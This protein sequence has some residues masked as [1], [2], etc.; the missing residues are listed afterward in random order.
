MRAEAAVA[1][2]DEAAV[3]ET[4]PGPTATASSEP[5]RIGRGD[6]SARPARSRRRPSRARRPSRRATAAPRG[7]AS[8]ATPST[9]TPETDAAGPALAV[10]ADVTGAR[11]R[12]RGPPRTERAARPG[13]RDEGAQVLPHDDVG[14]HR[15]RR[16]VALAGLE[17]RPVRLREAGERHGEGQE[18]GRDPRRAR[19][20]GERDP[21]QARVPCASAPRASR[22]TAGRSRAAATATANATRPGRTRSTAAAA[23]PDGELV[24]RPPRRSRGSRAPRAARRPR[25]GRAHRTPRP[26]RLDRDRHGDH[27]GR[28]GGGRKAEQEPAGDSTL[29]REH[30]ADGRPGRGGRDASGGRRR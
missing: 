7:R 21:G 19:G 13:G 22:P 9:V 29:S 24:R 1:L 25:Q 4:S 28:D 18:R 8:G 10:S 3:A 16:L 12:R 15:E 27:S 5:E 30:V 26:A 14:R 2:L 23:P 6:R 20:A 17:G 11:P